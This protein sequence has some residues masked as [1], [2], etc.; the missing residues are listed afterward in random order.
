VKEVCS[1][2]KA[3]GREHNQNSRTECSRTL[4]ACA[5]EK[6]GAEMCEVEKVYWEMWY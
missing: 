6:Y 5:M 2:E 4:K 1:R 3:C